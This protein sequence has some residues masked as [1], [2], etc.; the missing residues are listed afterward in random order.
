MLLPCSEPMPSGSN[1]T[2]NQIA[3]GVVDADLDV[4]ELIS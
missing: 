3:V 1:L 4:D 2:L